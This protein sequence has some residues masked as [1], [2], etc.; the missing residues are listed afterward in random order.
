MYVKDLSKGKKILKL[1]KIK[2]WTIYLIRVHPE[3]N[4]FQN[5]LLNFGLI[6]IEEKKNG[7]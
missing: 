2:D 1:I 6:Y 4:I 3:L 5:L 7:N